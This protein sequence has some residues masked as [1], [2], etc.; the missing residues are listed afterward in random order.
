MKWIC[1]YYYYYFDFTLFPYYLCEMLL[2]KFSTLAA[3][4]LLIYLDDWRTIF[5]LV[6]VKISAVH[7]LMFLIGTSTYGI[8]RKKY[9]THIHN[10]HRSA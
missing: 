4:G 5:E 10:H 8:I 3:Y 7:V 2:Y 6:I 1:N 9:Q